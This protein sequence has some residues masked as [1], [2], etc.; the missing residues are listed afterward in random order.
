MPE[1]IH[2]AYCLDDG[3]AEC[4]CVSMASVLANTKSKVHFHV[5]SNRLSDENKAKL[6]FLS[7]KFSHGQWSFHEFSFCSNNFETGSTHLTAETYYRLYFPEIFPDLERVLYLDGDIVVNGDIYELWD[8]NLGNY[9]AGVVVDSANQ[10][11]IERNKAL[12]FNSDDLYFNAGVMLINLR[13]F[14]KYEFS[15]HISAIMPELYTKLKEVTSSWCAD[16]EL[17]NYKFNADKSALFLSLKYNFMDKIYMY[18]A[19]LPFHRGCYELKDWALAYS[20]P[21]IIHY[22]DKKKPFQLDRTFQNAYN[23]R[24]YYKYKAMTPFYDPLDEGRI[25]EYNRC[26]QLTKTE[27]L[28]PINIYIRM[29]WQDM[30]INS[31]KKVKSI[32]GNRKLAFWGAGKHITHI[33]AMFAS[34]GLYPDIVVDGLAD[35]H[36]KT[37]FEYTVQ[38]AEMLRGKSDEYFVVLCMEAKNA[39]DS[40]IKSLKEYG[41]DE[42]GFMHAYAEAYERECLPNSYNA[43]SP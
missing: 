41:Y 8:T 40:V 24:L 23:W 6:S 20:S 19:P 18:M 42:N 26:E 27:S 12:D 15:R 35:N 25:A 43:T 21:V 7:K 11:F 32:I 37:V 33:M 29:F 4:T 1:T 34:Q 22:S 31:A 16:Q 14:G 2:I 3:F 30:F 17:L 5:V 10:I 39:R 9:T 38:P 28:L 36:G 13:K